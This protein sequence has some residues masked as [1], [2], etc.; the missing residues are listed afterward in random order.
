MLLKRNQGLNV[1]SFFSE[2][3]S[4]VCMSAA[5]LTDKLPVISNKKSW[6]SAHE[7]GNNRIKNSDCIH[8]V[9]VTPRSSLHI[10]LGSSSSASSSPLSPS[11]PSLEERRRPGTLF[12]WQERER[13]QQQQKEKARLILTE[14]FCTFLLF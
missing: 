2:S 12:I 5:S 1:G 8:F 11:S 3:P 10:E 14:I 7:L 13:L 9:S 4:L 6:K